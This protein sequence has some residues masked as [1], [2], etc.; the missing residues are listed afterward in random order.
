M[1]LL[2]QVFGLELILLA[3]L[4]EVRSALTEL[5]INLLS[6]A[7][8]P[9]VQHSPRHGFHI[10]IVSRSHRNYFFLTARQ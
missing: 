2:A 5:E 10:G 1:R 3:I 7:L 9:D 6:D 8:L 4:D